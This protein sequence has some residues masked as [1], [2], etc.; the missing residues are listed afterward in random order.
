[1]DILPVGS[2]LGLQE[3]SL[4]SGSSTFKKLSQSRLLC[5]VVTAIAKLATHHSELVP[6]A[7]VSLAK[8]NLFYFVIKVKIASFTFFASVYSTI[9]ALTKL[10]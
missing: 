8:V 5:F 4:G 3:S 2:R 1:M 6:R 10:T 9:F 7:R